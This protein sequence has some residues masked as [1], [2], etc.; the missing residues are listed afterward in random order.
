MTDRRIDERGG[1][2]FI[3]S[4]VDGEWVY[5]TRT[6][7]GRSYQDYDE[8]GKVVTRVEPDRKAPRSFRTKIEAKTYLQREDLKNNDPR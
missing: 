2:F 7:F 4:L 5:E 3:Q 8:N 6:V 1:Q